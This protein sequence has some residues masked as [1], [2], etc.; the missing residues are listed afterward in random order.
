MLLRGFSSKPLGRRWELQQKATTILLIQPGTSM[1]MNLHFPHN[2][3]YQHNQCSRALPNL[4][5]GTVT[6]SCLHDKFV[7]V[8]ENPGV[9]CLSGRFCCLS[10]HSNEVLEEACKEGRHTCLLGQAG[11]PTPGFWPRA[12]PCWWSLEATQLWLEGAKTVPCISDL[13]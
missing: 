12:L 9:Q 6:V 3:G 1:W 5:N 10:Q 2:K 13:P 8:W 11:A 7:H 4:F